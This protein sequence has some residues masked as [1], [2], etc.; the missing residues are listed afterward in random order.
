MDTEPQT[1]P[2]HPFFDQHPRPSYLTGAPQAPS[3]FAT[4]VPQPVER[5][6]GEHHSRPSNVAALIGVA[7]LSATVA[8]ASTIGMMSA[9][10]VTVDPTAAPIA[11]ATQQP[12]VQLAAENDTAADL[13]EIVAKAT[14]SVVTITAQGESRDMF[15]PFSVPSTGVGSGVIVSANGLI[16]TNNHVIENA[17]TLSVTTADG[18][19]LSATVV[20]AD[21]DHD[22]AVIRATGGNLTP[23]T[24]GDSDKIKVGETVLA[25]G[26][27]LGEFTE[28]VTRGIV[29]ALDRS[30]TVGDQFSGRG[31]NLSDLIQTDAAINP[32]NSGGA[33]INE[34]GEVIGINT[35]IA[36]SAQGIGFAIPINAAKALIDQATGSVS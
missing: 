33:L 25:I 29:S 11:Q 9:F 21:P 6:P 7:V 5:K 35:A 17:N 13:T 10:G 27:P 22:L 4:P 18:Q 23:A 1:P 15:S 28:T 32:G 31:E 34:R 16:L 2:Q 8:A 19:E 24:L 26:S 30:I 36:G 14:N 12:G 3:P 20:K